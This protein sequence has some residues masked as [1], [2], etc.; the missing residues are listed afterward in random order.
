M[1]F[2]RNCLWSLGLLLAAS[3]V[4]AAGFAAPP[5]GAYSAR[6]EERR[7]PELQVQRMTKMLDLTADQQ[8]KL[9]PL[10]VDERKKMNAV[11]D[12]TNLDRQAKSDKI[13]KIR[14]DANTQVRALLNT[15]Q[16]EKYDKML[17]ERQDSTQNQGGD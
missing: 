9:K 16:K 1:T 15:Q 7:S 13:A 11:R 6:M 3:F 4:P 17:E 12:D 8:A 14:Q 10:L 5:Q 2:N